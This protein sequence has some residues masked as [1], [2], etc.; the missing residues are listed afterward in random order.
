MPMRAWAASR[1]TVPTSQRSTSDWGAAMTRTPIMRLA[2]HLDSASEISAPAE[3]EHGRKHQQAAQAALRQA[4]AENPFD[5]ENHDAQQDQHRKIGHDEQ[6]NALHRP[7]CFGNAT[8][9]WNAAG[10]MV[11]PMRDNFKQCRQWF[12]QAQ[13]LDRERPRSGHHRPSVISRAHNAGF[14]MQFK[15]YYDTLGVNARRRRRGDQAR[16]SQARAQVPSG[17]EQR[18][19]RGGEVQG[20]AGGLRGPEG[21]RKAG[22]LRPAGPRLPARPAISAAA[23]LGAA[24]RPLGQ[25]SILR[26][27]R[28]Q[29]FLLEPV[30]RCRRRCRRGVRRPSAP[31]QPEAE[32]G[33]SGGQVE[34]AFRARSRRVTHPWRRG[35]LR[36]VDVQIPAGI[37]DGQALRI[38]GGGR[39]A[40][41][42]SASRCVRTRCIRLSGKDV[43][44]ELPL[45]PWEAALGA[46]GGRA[47]PR[48]DRGA[49]HPA[50]AQSGQK[51]Q[52]PR[53]RACRR[54]RT[55]ISSCHQAGHPGR[56]DRAKRGRPTSA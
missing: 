21:P 12:G 11:G 36:Q 37:A 5:D 35:A 13:P 9:L 23:R 30:R 7:F 48:R 22:H 54:P 20:R 47:D 19:E 50:G 39:A 44:I 45:A 34:E 2:V 25:P 1:A 15:D 14:G 27:E 28:L 6:E 26:S 38:G 10:L 17:R 55:E 46:E 53:P 31:A 32:A 24:F 43:Q 16:L 18:E 8:T 4:H 33:S 41:R 56:G 40:L 3:A 52:A 51:L 42:S 49:D 29:R